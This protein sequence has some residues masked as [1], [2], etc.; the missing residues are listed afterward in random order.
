[1]PLSMLSCSAPSIKI[2]ANSP[3]IVSA[4]FAS[5]TTLG[6]ISIQNIVGKYTAFTV[7]RTGGSQ[8]NFTSTVIS[9][10]TNSYTD[11]TTLSDGVQYT[12]TVNPIYGSKNGTP[13]TIITNPN[14]G[15]TP[16]KIYTLASVLPTLQN[17][18]GSTSTVA[19]SW[20][21]SGYSSITVQ[22][23]TL[24]G[25]T[26]TYTTASGTTTYSSSG[27]DT[28]SVNTQYAYRFKATNGDNV[29]NPTNF[30]VTTCTWA[31][32]PSLAYNGSG[33]STSAVSFTFSGG[34][35]SNL[36]IQTTLGT[37]IT[38]TT[39]SPYTSPSSYSTNQQITYYVV[40]INS[41]GYSNNTNYTSVNTCTWAACNTPS[42]SSTSGNGTSLAC[43]GT[44]SSVNVT[45]SGGTASPANNTNITGTNSISQGY[46]GMVPS[47]QYTFVCAP[48]N[49][50]NY[51][52][53]NTSTQ[54]V[55][56]TALLQTVYT[57]PTALDFTANGNS[58]YNNRGE[59]IATNNDG[60]YIAVGG[61]LYIYSSNNSG[62]TFTKKTYTTCVYSVSMNFSG[63]Y[64]VA[65]TTGV[66]QID[67]YTSNNYG[68]TWT[69]AAS[70]LSI[71]NTGR[72]PGTTCV[73][74]SGT[75]M[76]CA[77]AGGAGFENYVSTNSGTSF[78]LSSGGIYNRISSVM[79]SVNNRAI[80]IHVWGFQLT[81]NTLGYANNLNTT[82][83][84]SV[85]GAPA[86]WSRDAIRITANSSCTRFAV[87]LGQGNTG[88][89]LSNDGSNWST[90]SNTLTGLLVSGVNICYSYDAGT[91]VVAD[92]S[93][94]SYSHDY[95][96]TWYKY[97]TSL[98]NIVYIKLSG[99]GKVLYIVTS[100]S[101]LYKVII[102]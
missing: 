95:G 65:T 54:S 14:N 49:A 22:N 13:F 90:C 4:A 52:S 36:S 77:G 18:S 3:V 82:P 23:L 81:S 84:E 29:V 41:L 68:S 87:C 44:F 15:G 61:N 64:Q 46:F 35:Y 5:P 17:A 21:N 12:Y 33:S 40:P 100:S 74:L 76:H 1:M 75:I 2:N 79:D 51:Q 96:S 66:P 60:T 98:T 9:A 70:A 37:Q 24:S 72:W 73:N 39:S 97:T 48:V 94:I 83:T 88:I 78:G 59:Y 58:A 80:F 31:S 16:G 92:T 55:T 8:G 25:T 86:G 91:L 19:L 71:N 10:P 67:F 63:Q 62:S 102:S 85:P 47:T 38:T 56:T 45:Y 32:V 69:A 53:T 57:F 99:D 11:T 34:S 20:T 42:F 26:N 6:R 28:L 101:I 89:L 50:L 7:S 93:V 30:D 27:I 43:T